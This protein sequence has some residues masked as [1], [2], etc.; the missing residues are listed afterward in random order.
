MSPLK[1]Y[2]VSSISLATGLTVGTITSCANKRGWSTKGGLDLS[3]IL[4]VL[5]G[6]RRDRGGQPDQREVEELKDI[7]VTIGAIEKEE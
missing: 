1:K 6:E 2:K 5:K 7:L 4:A 3:Q